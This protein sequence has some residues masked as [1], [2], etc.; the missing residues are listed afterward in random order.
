MKKKVDLSLNSTKPLKKNGRQKY[1]TNYANTGR[2]SECARSLSILDNYDYLYY[3]CEHRFNCKVGN[4]FRGKSKF[5]N[6]F[7]EKVI[8]CK[9]RDRFHGNF[10]IKN[11]S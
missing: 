4:K 9:N 11:I 6:Y 2:R 1:I 10:F 3:R 7:A 8:Y 5:Y